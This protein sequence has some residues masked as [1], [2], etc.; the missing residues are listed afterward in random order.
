MNSIEMIRIIWNKAIAMSSP[1]FPIPSL[2]C[3][4]SFS[5]L[6]FFL[7]ADSLEKKVL[8]TI[9]AASNNSLWRI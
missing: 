5:S 9:P 2:F 8:S 3:L 4:I 6:M 7:G 1:F